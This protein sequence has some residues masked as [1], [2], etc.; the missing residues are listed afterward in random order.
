ML[1]NS[2]LGSPLILR[3]RR[4]L[5]E[6]QDSISWDEVSRREHVARYFYSR[7]SSS[8]LLYH[9]N[10]LCREGMMLAGEDRIDTD[11]YPFGRSHCPH[12]SRRRRS[13]WFQR[14]G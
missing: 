2:S 11:V 3:R 14:G 8:P 9:T 1:A 6:F 10:L 12:C 13:R 5:N 7:S 4:I